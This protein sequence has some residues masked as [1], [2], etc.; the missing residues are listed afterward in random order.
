MSSFAAGAA[1]ERMPRKKQAAMPEIATST[2]QI[3]L[4]YN[5]DS[6]RGKKAL[7]LAKSSGLPIREIDILETPLTGV[8][9]LEIADMLQLK[10]ADLV[11]REH[12]VF[13]NRFGDNDFNEANLLTM[14]EHNPDILKQPIAI[15]GDKAILVEAPTDILQL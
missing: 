15:K 7:A 11:N 1:P 9:I 2:R 8:Q 5:S 10:V 4:F 3:T 12:P 14:I 6:T 13:S